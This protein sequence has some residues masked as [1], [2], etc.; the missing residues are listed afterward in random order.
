[1]VQCVRR[2]SLTRPLGGPSIGVNIGIV[3][4]ARKVL[5]SRVHAVG[6][7]MN[8]HSVHGE[9]EPMTHGL[10]QSARDEEFANPYLG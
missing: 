10:P 5:N 4:A 3:Q 1:M 2:G 9:N 6:R 7:V 8:G